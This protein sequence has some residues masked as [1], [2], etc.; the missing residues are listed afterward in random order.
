MRNL[1]FIFW[2]GLLV[3]CSA[4]DS[5]KTK[6]YSPPKFISWAKYLSSF[7]GKDI[8]QPQKKFGYSFITRDLEGGKKAF[9][10]HRS[11]QRSEIYGNSRYI[12]GSSNTFTCEWSFVTNDKGVV[13]DYQWNGNDCPRTIR[14]N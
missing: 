12:A 10:W 3:G 2:F 6:D 13:L 14:L 4:I 11:N 1:L 8:S 9:V 7:V 5:L